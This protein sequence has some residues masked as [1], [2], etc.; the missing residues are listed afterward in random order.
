M[1]YGIAQECWRR[2]GWMIEETTEWFRIHGPRYRGRPWRYFFIEKHVKGILLDMGSGIA[3]TTRDLLRRGKIKQ[4][5]LLDLS[6]TSLQTICREEPRQQCIL[7]DMLDPP[8]NDNTFDTITLFASLHNIPGRLC[9]IHVLHEA[10]RMLRPGGVLI[11]TVWARYQLGMF[12]PLI[13][14]LIDK[15]T[16]RTESFGDVILGKKPPRRYYHLYSLREL[17]SDIRQSGFNILD[18]GVFWQ[19]PRLLLGRNKNYYVVA[20]KT[21]I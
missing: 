10:Y 5:V 7:G 9:R 13:K 8:F 21:R 1:N 11:V 20:I 15:L 4:L 2:Y 17:L 14:S 16:G 18:K 3:S 6:E 19:G 12:K